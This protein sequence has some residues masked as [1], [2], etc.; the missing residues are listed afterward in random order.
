MRFQLWRALHCYILTKFQWAD[1]LQW[2]ISL[3]LQRCFNVLTSVYGVWM[4]GYGL[5]NKLLVPLLQ[6][7]S[8][9]LSGIHTSKDPTKLCRCR[10]RGEDF[11]ELAG[12]LSWIELWA[13]IESIFLSLGSILLWF[14]WK[15]EDMWNPMEANPNMEEFVNIDL[16][17]KNY[18]SEYNYPFTKRDFR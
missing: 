9:S 8:S 1:L 5:P 14:I 3:L 16:C 2:P 4:N 11:Q 10:Y 15:Y 13:G 7:I 18:S 17:Q 6:S 12:V